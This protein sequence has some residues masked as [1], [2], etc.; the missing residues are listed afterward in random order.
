MTNL[1]DALNVQG[2]CEMLLLRYSTINVHKRQGEFRRISK[3]L[4]EQT[5]RRWT[6][7]LQLIHGQSENSIVWSSVEEVEAINHPEKI[8][9]IMKQV[10]NRIETKGEKNHELA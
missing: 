10:I 6:D 8:P 5:Y 9:Q 4:I 1:N 3:M 2:Q 7:S